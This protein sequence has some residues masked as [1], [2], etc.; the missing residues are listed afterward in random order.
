MRVKGVVW[1]GTRTDRFAEMREFFRTITGA[2]PWLD[3]PDFAVFDLASGDRLEV[4]GPSDTGH[5]W[6][7]CPLAGFLV[8][9]VEAAR[10]ELEAYGV[11]FIGPVHR[12]RD[13]GNAWAHFRAPDGH[14]YEL[15]SQPGH[16]AHDAS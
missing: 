12:D 8:E 5:E 13:G 4:F 15:T 10:A 16:P 7:T 2:E 11:E 9:N 3:E 6:M 14:V 1:L